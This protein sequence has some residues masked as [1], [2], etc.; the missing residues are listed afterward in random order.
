[1][2]LSLLRAE[3]VKRGVTQEIMANSLG[4]KDKSSYCLMENG[5]TAISVDIANK[6]ANFLRFT[7]DLTYEI[8]FT[9]EVQ[10]TS[11]NTIIKQEV[12]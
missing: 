8:F 5:K 4:F 7:P 3:R 1:M 12:S 11:A 10:E 2:N 9:N 6:I